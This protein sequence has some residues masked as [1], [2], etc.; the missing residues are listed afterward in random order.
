[1]PQKVAM[2]TAEMRG[3]RSESDVSTLR[4]EPSSVMGL[5]W[6]DKTASSSLDARCP[7]FYSHFR[8]N[9]ATV[10][11]VQEGA[12][13]THE[14]VATVATWERECAVVYQESG[15]VAT[16]CQELLNDNKDSKEDTVP[17]TMEETILKGLCANP[18]STSDSIFRVLVQ[19]GKQF[20]GNELLPIVAKYPRAMRLLSSHYLIGH[21]DATTGFRLAVLQQ[22]YT[23]AAAIVGKVAIGNLRDDTEGNRFQEGLRVYKK[24]R[25]LAVP[26]RYPSM[27]SQS[28]TER[29]EGHVPH[30]TALLDQSMTLE[31]L[32]LLETQQSITDTLALPPNLL[33]G[34]SLIETIQKL[35]ALHAMHRRALLLAVDLAERYTVPPRQFWWT[36]LRVLAQTEQ[37]EMLYKLV[38]ASRPAIGYVPIAEVLLDDGK[39]DLVQK[40]VE[41]IADQ[42]ERAQVVVLMAED[43]EER[44]MDTL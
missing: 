38:Q 15:A 26:T 14:L 11:V 35:I 19:L 3:E 21:K 42:E 41:F 40:M 34:C 4:R 16:T 30:G 8:H 39:Y 22:E 31:L 1:M 13:D 24:Y 12:F 27:W 23:Q 6:S 18:L 28:A 5:S 36:L 10:A 43:E 37:W 2:L 20:P 32:E 33:I 7:A 29:H 44:P 17:V 25:D 9:V